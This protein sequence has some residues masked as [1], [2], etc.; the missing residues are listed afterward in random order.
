M[1]THLYLLSIFFFLTI[2]V[3]FGTCSKKA[4]LNQFDWEKLG[5]FLANGTFSGRLLF[6]QLT[7]T[8]DA[9]SAL[10]F[11]K[12]NQRYAIY[13]NPQNWQF[14]FNNGTYYYLDGVC[15]Y[16]PKTYQDFV[17]VYRSAVE[18]STGLSTGCGSAS[19]FSGLVREPGACNQSVAI[20]I[21]QSTSSTKKIVSFSFSQ[22]LNYVPPPAFVPGHVTSSIQYE[23]WNFGTPKSQYFQLPKNCLDPS[24]LL[25]YCQ[26]Y[27]PSPYLFNTP[28]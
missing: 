18:S 1:A 2:L 8:F 10:A 28:V 19:I 4:P 13:I 25:D 14:G 9:P 17:T 11:D 20:T 16:V 6:P 22:V 15:S 12:S 23:K 27:Y 21:V 3:P 7:D 26:I 24:K 5:S